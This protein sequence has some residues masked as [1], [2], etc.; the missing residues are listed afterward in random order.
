MGRMGHVVSPEPI[1]VVRRMGYANWPGLGQLGT[2]PGC[3]GEDAG[4]LG[5][6]RREKI[7]RVGASST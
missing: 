7:V 5:I 4:G 3:G 2:C 6:L 1:S